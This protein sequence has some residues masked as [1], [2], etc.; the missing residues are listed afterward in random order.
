M[1]LA[2]G[3]VAAGRE[4]RTLINVPKAPLMT[5]LSSRRHE[6]IF[7]VATRGGYRYLGPAPEGMPGQVCSG[8]NQQDFLESA[9]E[10]CGVS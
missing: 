2:L 7:T 3:S 5:A 10:P 8:V 4:P 6:S 1:T 9:R